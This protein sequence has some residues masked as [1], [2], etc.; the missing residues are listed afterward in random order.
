MLQCTGAGSAWSLF[1]RHLK[2]DRTARSGEYLAFIIM[3]AMADIHVN[4]QEL[5]EVLYAA[6]SQDPVQVRVSTERLKALLDILGTY[7]ALH[8]IAAEKSYPPEMRKQS[9]IQF[10]N[11][12]HGHWR[13]RKY[14]FPCGSIPP[15]YSL[16]CSGYCQTTIDIAFVKGVWFFYTKR[17]TWYVQRVFVPFKSYLH[18]RSQNVTS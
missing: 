18:H 1:G 7:D 4:R 12:A 3:N 5:L 8:E 6:S 17:T 13:S 10:K 15:I 9:I 14:A 2:S 11:F 16:L